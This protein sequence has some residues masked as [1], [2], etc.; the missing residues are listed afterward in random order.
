MDEHFQNVRSLQYCN[1]V[2]LTFFVLALFNVRSK[3]TVKFLAV[4]YSGEYCAWSKLLLTSLSTISY[5]CEAMPFMSLIKKA[6][7]FTDLLAYMGL[8]RTAPSQ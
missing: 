2:N 5:V 7:G 8:I 1:R 3:Y 6:T 4:L